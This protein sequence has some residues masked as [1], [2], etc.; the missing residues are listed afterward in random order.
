MAQPNLSNNQLAATSSAHAQANRHHLSTIQLRKEV[1]QLHP[2]TEPAQSQPPAKRR[3]GV[4]LSLQGWKKFQAAKTQV[5]FDENAGDRFTLEEL[6]ERTNLSLNT[7]SKALGRSE[8]VDK[9]IITVGIPCLWLG[10]KQK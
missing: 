4:I 7:I 6:S 3:R 2:P 5:E 8:P 1:R 10:V 9:L